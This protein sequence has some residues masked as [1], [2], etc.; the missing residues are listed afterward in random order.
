MTDKERT[1]QTDKSNENQTNKETD[2]K[3]SFFMLFVLAEMTVDN[4]RKK[5]T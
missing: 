2:K 3:I 4:S 1:R 5:A